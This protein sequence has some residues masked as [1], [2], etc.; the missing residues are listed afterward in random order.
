[1]GK[2]FLTVSVWHHSCLFVNKRVHVFSLFMSRPWSCA[3]TQYQQLLWTHQ[4]QQQWTV[5]SRCCNPPPEGA[6]H[7]KLR[8]P[9]SHRTTGFS[10]QM[11][12]SSGISLWTGW[13]TWML[14]QAAHCT[15]GPGPAHL[16]ITRC[17]RA[18]R[19]LRDPR[20]DLQRRPP[21][22]AG[23]RTGLSTS[24]STTQGQVRSRDES[25]ICLRAAG[26]ILSRVLRPS[27]W[28]LQPIQTRPVHEEASA[29]HL[30]CDV[31]QPPPPTWFYFVY[32]FHCVNL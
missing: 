18:A 20:A 7:S 25:L 32:L 21:H 28:S 14:Q 4:A 31:P 16:E 23:G 9:A 3:C 5:F 22:T 11:I 27:R 10:L 8:K 1:M 15:E 12:R 24:T 30:S 19:P 13:R 29:G 6:T 17:R 26:W 2:T